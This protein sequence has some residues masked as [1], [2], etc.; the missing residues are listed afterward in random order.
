MRNVLEK[1]PQM[2]KTL[3]SIDIRSFLAKIQKSNSLFE[4]VQDFFIFWSACR[5][6]D[7]FIY[8]SSEKNLSDEGLKIEKVF[9]SNE[10]FSQLFEE[11]LLIKEV[12]ART[13]PPSFIKKNQV[14][15]LFLTKNFQIFVL[16]DNK[17]ALHGLLFD[18][19]LVLFEQEKLLLESLAFAYQSL[20][21]IEEKNALVYEDDLTG[22]YNHRYLY[23][24]LDQEIK[25]SSRYL[26]PFSLIFVD[27]DQFKVINDTYGHLVGSQILSQMAK[28]FK[29]LLR[30]VDIIIRYGGDEF[31]MILIGSDSQQAFQVCQRIRSTVESYP[32]TAEGTRLC[33]TV[34]IGLACFPEHTKRK[35]LLI[36]YADQ[37]M[38]QSKKQGRNRVSIWSNHKNQAAN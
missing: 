15:E 21:Y 8:F 25:R 6:L 35:D 20:F 17:S 26:Q 16:L 32:F 28:V 12:L 4:K 5:H 23:L 19:N 2:R 29:L 7:N 13:Q 9:K 36:Q 27:L 18:K 33:L 34:S 38:Y 24:A 22:L 3:S 31:V 11:R 1:Q 14:Q 30:E 10:P 37:A